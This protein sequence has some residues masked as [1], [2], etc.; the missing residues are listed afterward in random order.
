MR[1]TTL[2]A[3]LALMVAAGGSSLPR[4]KAAGPFDDLLN[5]TSANTNVLVLIDVKGAFASPLAKTEKWAEKIQTSNHGALG[6]VPPDAEAVVIAGE[7]NLTTLVRD[8]QIGLV[9]VRNVPTMRD[10]AAREGG[11]ADE[12]AGRLTVLSPRDVYFTTFS[13]QEL[14]ALF[15]ADRQY[16]ARYLRAAMAAKEPPL[17]PF[18]KRAA[19]KAGENTVTI[20]VDLEDVVDRTV[21]RMSLPSSP[22]VTQIKGLDVNLLASFLASVKGLTFSAKITDAINASVTLEFVSD[23]T[24]F[25]RTM[26]DLLRE[27]I[28]S[29]GI[30]IQGFEKWEPTFTD[31]TMTLSGKLTGGDLQRI[32]SLFAFPPAPGEYDPKVKGDEPSAPMT[33]RYIAAVEAVL[34]NIR[35]LRDTPNYEKTAT[36]HDKAAAQIEQLSKRG[37][38]PAAVDAAF[39]ASKGLHAIASS[40][41]GTPIDLE[42]L[43]NQ[44][45]YYS[46]PSIGMVPGGFWG[47]QPFMFGPAQV[48]TNIPKIQAEM[49]RVVAED[50]KKRQEV[51]SKID[52]TLMDTRRKLSEKFK[53]DI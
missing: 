44:Q 36:W 50:K 21:L 30:A 20:A 24:R 26:P 3:G 5:R 23:P 38:D 33:R 15:P 13:G 40:L 37:V 35:S 32:L 53:T 17:H 34:A 12:I 48:D 52:R 45:F 22:A 18:L 8:F 29:Q 4:A 16:V 2:A 31:T 27:L 43:A 6:F 47:W 46:R 11:T 42:A 41:R 9:R 14:V 49:A 10:L 25:R 51:W 1:R 28:E 7:V 39:Q 19:A